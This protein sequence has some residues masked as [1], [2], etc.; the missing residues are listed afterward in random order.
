MDYTCNGNHTFQNGTSMIKRKP[1]LPA[2][3]I[4]QYNRYPFWITE[5]HTG[6][7]DILRKNL[8]VEDNAWQAY[9]EDVLYET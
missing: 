5:N 9:F 3:Y 1:M 6:V 2:F 4:Y 7:V 8:L